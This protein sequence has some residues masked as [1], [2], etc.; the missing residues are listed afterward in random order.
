ML[1]E[2]VESEEQREFLNA[3]LCQ[4]AQGYLFGRPVPHADIDH[5][6]NG[7]ADRG[8]FAPGLSEN[9]KRAKELRK[10]VG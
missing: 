5:I 2:G 4:Q 8:S 7:E 3:E 1:A 10:A 9:P 6:V